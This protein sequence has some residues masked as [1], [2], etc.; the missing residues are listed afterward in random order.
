MRCHLG[1]GIL[2]IAGYHWTRGGACG[3]CFITLL[4]AVGRM[5][6]MLYYVFVAGGRK[7]EPDAWR[8]APG[9]FIKALSA[10]YL[11][12]W[13]ALLSKADSVMSQ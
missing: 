7:K 6:S 1:G 4:D 12:P 13:N 11:R 10:R 3:A 5:R 9:S 8:Y 2:R